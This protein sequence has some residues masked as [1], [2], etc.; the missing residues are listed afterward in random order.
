VDSDKVHAFSGGYAMAPEA[1]DKAAALP[2]LTTRYKAAGTPENGEVSRLVLVMG[3]EGFKPGGTAYYHMQYVH[4]DIGEF[5]FTPNGHVFRF[6]FSGRQPKLVT[7]HGG[8]LLRICDYIAL[9][10]MPWIRQADRDFRLVG[11]G[12]DDELIITRIEVT[13][14]VR[15]EG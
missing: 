1:A 9:R 3:Q 2:G 8:G 12:A 13:D 14:W 5:G 6:V 11:G 10:R 7:V 15:L 4:I